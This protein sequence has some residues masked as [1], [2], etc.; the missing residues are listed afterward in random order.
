MKLIIVRHGVASKTEDS[1][2]AI[3]T[4]GGAEGVLRLAAFLAGPGAAAPAEIRHSTKLRARQT[5]D[6]IAESLPGE[7]PVFETDGLRPNDPVADLADELSLVSD[8]LIVVSHLPFVDQLASRLVFDDETIQGFEFAPSTAV[9]LAREDRIG[10]PRP[11]RWRV[12]W[13]TSPGLLP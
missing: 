10:G 8:E 9:C 7:I 12:V 1:P 11:T 2:E 6:L 4:E 13:M 3:L 5:A